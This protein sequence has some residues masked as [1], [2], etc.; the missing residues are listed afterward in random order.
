MLVGP[1]SVSDVPP[2]LSCYRFASQVGH[3]AIS[4]PSPEADICPSGPATSC[5]RV[6]TQRR[7]HQ[8]PSRND[9]RARRHRAAPSPLLALR[10]N[11]DNRRPVAGHDR[12]RD[13]ASF[14][15]RPVKRQA[16]DRRIA[17][18]RTSAP[19]RSQLSRESRDPSWFAPA[20]HEDMDLDSAALA[21]ISDT[22]CASF[23]I[24]YERPFNMPLLPRV[25]G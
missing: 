2:R 10:C 5:D 3:S 25:S 20:R 18:L 13:C 19:M 17:Q 24:Q 12:D 16:H 6:R 23:D 8:R 11:S 21:G 7:H 15:E 9:S 22:A 1:M 14:E 4:T